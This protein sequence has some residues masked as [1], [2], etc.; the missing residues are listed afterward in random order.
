MDAFIL[1]RHLHRNLLHDHRAYCPDACSS[2]VFRHR[3]RNY[4][5]AAE[6]G[7]RGVSFGRRCSSLDPRDRG[8]GISSSNLILFSHQL[9][10]HRG[11]PYPQ[12]G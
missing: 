9:P 1:T 12:R 3:L 8:T 11:F 2:Q 10:L 7:L 4:V 5:S 6:L